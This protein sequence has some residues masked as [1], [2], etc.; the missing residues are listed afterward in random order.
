M[1][2][3]FTQLDNIFN[4]VAKQKC[5]KFSKGRPGVKEKKRLVWYKES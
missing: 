1:A 4:K 3:L 2:E 5:R